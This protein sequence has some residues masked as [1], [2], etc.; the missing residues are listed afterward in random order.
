MKMKRFVSTSPFE[1]VLGLALLVA[2][3]LCLSGGRCAAAGR[4]AASQ[5][6]G[7]GSYST[8]G[9]GRRPV[10]QQQQPAAVP[11]LRPFALAPLGFLG[12][13]VAGALLLGRRR[14]R[15]VAAALEARV[16]PLRGM[17]R[18]MALLLGVLCL[19]GLGPAGA[20]EPEIPPMPRLEDETSPD[21]I[22]RARVQVQYL[23]R[24]CALE[25]RKN[26]G[27][28]QMLVQLPGG[29]RRFGGCAFADFAAMEVAEGRRVPPFKV[30][31]P[32]WVMSGEPSSPKMPDAGAGSEDPPPDA[33]PKPAPVPTLRPAEEAVLLSVPLS[34]RGTALIVGGLLAFGVGAEL[35]CWGL[36][37]AAGRF[38]G[39]LWARVVPYLPRRRRL[40]WGAM[41]IGWAVGLLF[42]LV[43][44]WWR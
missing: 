6:G 7:T 18:G 15:K 42:G 21:L 41:V 23:R 17:A 44:A 30:I 12:A 22:V 14:A 3:L 5:G 11:P 24:G 8:M 36:R 4:E 29:I 37:G 1:I 38:P 31:T 40:L 27:E 10:A 35:V 28:T 26:A 43:R 39:G 16:R 34:Y 9:A 33:E 32:S 19:S 2:G 13:F 25:R 20:A